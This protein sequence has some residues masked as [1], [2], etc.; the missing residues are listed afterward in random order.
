[1]RKANKR[2]E[3]EKRAGRGGQMK[4]EK[5]RETKVWRKL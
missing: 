4:R 2:K 1:M 5:K 3:S